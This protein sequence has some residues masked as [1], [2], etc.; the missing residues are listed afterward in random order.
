VESVE[1]PT[2]TV[3]PEIL[4]ELIPT[5][6]KEEKT[7][8]QQVPKDRKT[9]RKEEKEEIQKILEE[10]NVTDLNE[11]EKEKLTE[12]DSLTGVPLPDDVLL[13][14]IP[15]CA[16]YSVL[17]KDK[18]K[19]KLTPGSGKRGKAGK[20]A[21]DIFLRLPQA[22]QQEKD[23]IKAINENEIINQIPGNIKISTPGLMK[24][25]SNKKKKK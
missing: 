6:K 18:F 10:E 11:E 25:V 2:K 3:D 17:A 15:V 24:S 20:Q 9:K 12:L 8:E 23:M 14:A 16:P 13:F 7:G 22:T 1:G 4:E 19:V 5:T 21:L